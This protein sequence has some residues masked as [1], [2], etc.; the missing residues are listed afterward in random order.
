M[1]G[2]LIDSEDAYSLITNIILRE[3]GRPDVPW[4]IKA[5][6]QGR[7]GPE[8]GRLFREWANLPIA[9]ADFLSRQ[10]E[11]QQ[12]IFRH[13]KP[14]PGAEDLLRRLSGAHTMA[15]QDERSPSGCLK[16]VHLA[17]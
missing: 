7:P 4:S 9:E 14:L 15:S 1:D 10:R 5:K 6:L 17:L 11:L 16:A 13:C 2:L 12:E 3:N 8:A